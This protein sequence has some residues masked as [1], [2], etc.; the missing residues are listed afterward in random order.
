MIGEHCKLVLSALD[1]RAQMMLSVALRDMLYQR[2]IVWQKVRR[3]VDSLSVPNLAV[4][5]T[6]NLWIK[7]GQE[8]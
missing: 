7:G 1:L 8:A 4:F 2:A 6:I 5:Q 3:N